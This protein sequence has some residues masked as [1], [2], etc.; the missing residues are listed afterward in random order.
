M[1]DGA[2]TILGAIIL[3]GAHQVA[4]QSITTM[5]EAVMASL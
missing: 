3:H 1:E 2:H 5:G 4:K